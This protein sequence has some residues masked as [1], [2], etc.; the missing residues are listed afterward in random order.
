MVDP[1]RTVESRYT[2]YANEVQTIERVVAGIGQAVVGKGPVVEKLVASALAGGHVLFEDYPGLGK[3][4]LVKT[5]SR[6]VGAEFKRVQ[7]TPDLLPS[8]IL[9]TTIWDQG[10][11]AFLLHKGPVFTNILLADEINRAP[12]K[13]QAALLEAM[14]ERQVTLDGKTLPLPKP[15]FVLA[16][17]NPVEQEGT[18]PLPEAQMDRFLLR[19][20][21]GYPGSDEEEASILAR[22]ASWKRDDPTGGLQPVLN[23]QGL[24]ALVNTVEQGVTVSPEVQLYIA[25]L[26]RAIRAH[27]RVRVGPSPRGS[28]ALFK[29]GKALALI[30]GRDFVVP[31]DI[32]SIAVDALAHRTLLHVEHLLAGE[33]ASRVVREVLDAVPVPAVVRRNVAQA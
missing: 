3:T 14:E 31:D 2:V 28:L 23:L 29:A 24:Q 21:M 8:D 6:I 10:Q 12:P 30:R 19:L 13:T 32:K 1:I 5:F 26:V 7:F 27:P 16:T 33:E 11:K 4:L 25:R 9:G 22:R 18:Y 15:F 20:T 17:Q